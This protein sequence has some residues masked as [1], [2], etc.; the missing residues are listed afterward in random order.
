LQAEAHLS[1]IVQS[2]DDAIISKSLDGTIISW[3]PAASRIFG[4][5]E[6]EMVGQSVRRLIPHDQQHEEDEILARTMAG[7]R[8]TAF[9]T[10]RLSKD[11]GIV[12]VSITVSP[13]RGP[14][15]KI[16]GVSTIAR[17][18]GPYLDA[19]SAAMEA[20]SRFRMLADNISQLAWMADA[21]GSIFWYNKRWYDYTGTTHA[22]VVG[23][24]WDIVHH[25]DHFE[26]V[27]ARFKACIEAREEWEDT[28]PLRCVDGGFRWFLSRAKPI[29]DD[30]NGVLYWFGTN[31]DVTDLLEKEEHIRVLLMEVNHR[32]KNMLS[33][34]QALARRSGGGDPAFLQRFESRLT[35]LSANQD[36]LVRRGWGTIPMEELADA[37]LAIL[38][39]DARAQVTLKGP[40][41]NLSPRAAEILGMAVHELA[42]NAL[43][44]GALSQP[45]GTVQLSW[46]EIRGR[47]CVAWTE[48]GGPAVTPPAATGF[49]TTLIRHIPARS[50]KADVVLDYLPKGII[51]RLECEAAVARDLVS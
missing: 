18:A 35:S 23:W 9:F 21:T 39:P 47:F 29:V 25:P 46:S 4:F 20:E 19:Q 16:V 32:S 7:E 15:G 6:D 41:I 11:G 24:G 3:N 8:I 37:Q 10:Q 51:W 27:K 34:V 43:K 44:Y 28:F 45:G 48:Q 40:A 30:R 38:D 1:A 33:V 2:S 5:T 31:T 12:R 50:L 13:I 36:L 26:R 14:D 17:D 49:G 22:Q 42:T